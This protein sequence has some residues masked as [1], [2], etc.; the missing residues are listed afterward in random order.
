[1]NV[2]CVIIRQNI[3]VIIVSTLNTKKHKKKEDKIG[4]KAVNVL[5]IEQKTDKKRTLVEKKDKKRIQK[6]HFLQK[7][8]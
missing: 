4:V 7:K 6:G 5:E 8:L 3:Q 1:M 2:N